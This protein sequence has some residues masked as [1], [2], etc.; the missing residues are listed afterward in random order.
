[1]GVY[2]LGFRVWD[3]GVLALGFWSLAFRMKVAGLRR[4]LGFGFSLLSRL[5]AGPREYC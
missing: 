1:M 3:L 5:P 4:A 2:R